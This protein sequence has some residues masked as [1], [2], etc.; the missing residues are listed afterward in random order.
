MKPYCSILLLVFTF[1][2][3]CAGKKK[4]DDSPTENEHLVS[5]TANHEEAFSGKDTTYIMR[6]V[7]DKSGLRERRSLPIQDL[8]ALD[9][10]DVKQLQMDLFN[11]KEGDTIYLGSGVYHLSNELIISEVN[12]ITIQGKG[13]GKTILNFANQQ[14]GGQG[15]NVNKANN[16]TLYDFSVY[17]AHGDGIKTKGCNNMVMR[18]LEVLWTKGPRPTNGGYGLYPVES[19]GILVERCM[20][21]GASDAGIYVGQSLDVVVKNCYVYHN[22][23]GI[24]IEN[25]TRS[26]VYD[27]VAEDNTGGILVFNLP[28]LP[29]NP[30]GKFCQVYDNIVV[31]NNHL[32]FAPEGNMVAIVAPGSGI[33]L[34]AA[35]SC[36]VFNNEIR[37]NKTMGVAVASYFVHNPNQKST[38]QFS[39]YSS[40]ISIRDNEYSC[41]PSFYADNSTPFGLLVLTSGN[42][43]RG[44][45]LLSDG[46]FSEEDMFCVQEDSS[47]FT[48]MMLN[49]GDFGSP[50]IRDA[51]APGNCKTMRFPEVYQVNR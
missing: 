21:A 36:E 13:M 33:V 41:D 45:D 11:A 1:C 17:D 30:D 24:E 2:F 39:P 38:D 12:G 37:D 16:I 31:H 46:V 14:A 29:V 5:Q 6:A 23:A 42:S 26:L 25:C 43:G 20:V 22:V 51:G 4:V 7:D 44:F 9:S 10:L 35:K 15:I 48:F 32:N 19:Q 47:D 27:N 40:D 28:D 50:L 8:S 49:N 3:S 18:N 34:L